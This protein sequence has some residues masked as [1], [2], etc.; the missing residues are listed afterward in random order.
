MANKE[1]NS[2]KISDFE[3]DQLREVVN[4]GASHASTA[5]S[6]MINKR[7]IIT[8]PVVIADKVENISSIIGSENEIVTAILSQ[9][10]GDAKGLMIFIFPHRNDVSSVANLIQMITKRDKK[11]STT[12]DEYDIA[13]LKELGNIL[14]GSSLTAFS[15]FLNLNMIHSVQESITDMLGSIVN[16]VMAEIAKATDQALIFKVI[17]QVEGEENNPEL[18]FFIDPTTTL[19]I[20]ESTNKKL[21]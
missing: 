17:F 7:I 5:M 6:Q 16:S 10:Y 9:I 14:S 1:N 20:L 3:I 12:L 21:K 4:I 8:V 13:V 18:Y 11:Q 19:R 15:K 2:T